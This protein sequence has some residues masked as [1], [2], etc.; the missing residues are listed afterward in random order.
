M[1]R[2]YLCLAVRGGLGLL[3]I[4]LGTP[5]GDQAPRPRGIRLVR[6][7]IRSRT[8][9]LPNTSSSGDVATRVVCL[10]GG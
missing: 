7:P 3:V 1:T 6:A 8:G 2:H 9:S 10:D 5:Q 4:L